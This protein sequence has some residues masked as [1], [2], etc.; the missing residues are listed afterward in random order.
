MNDPHV[1]SLLYRLDTDP[2]LVFQN[3]PPLDYETPDFR[4]RLEDGLL[5]VTMKGHYAS[6]EEAQ[7]VVQPFL[8]AWELDFAL[9]RGK[10]EM[11][12]RFEKAN[13]KDRN[14]PPPGSSQVLQP[15]AAECVLTTSAPMVVIGQR[16]YPPPPSTPLEVTADV[17]TL[18][19]RYERAMRDREPLPGAGYFCLTI[20]EN[21]FGGI[22]PAPSGPRQPSSKRRITATALDVHVDVLS[23]LGELTTER[24]DPTSTARKANIAGPLTPAEEEWVRAAL[25]QLIRRAAMIAAGSLPSHQLTM[26]DLPKLL[27]MLNDDF[28]TALDLC[29]EQAEVHRAKQAI[30]KDER[31]QLEREK[32]RLEKAIDRLMDQIEIGQSVKDRLKLR[33]EE[34]AQVK[35]RIAQADVPTLSRDLLADSLKPLGPLCALGVGDPVAIRQILRKIRR[36]SDHRDT[37]RERME[38]RGTGALQGGCTPKD[39]R[40]APQ[41]PRARKRP[42]VAVT[43]LELALRFEGLEGPPTPRLQAAGR[44]AIR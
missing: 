10:R 38:V 12:F 6:A 44:Y 13:L 26:A 16:S 40:G 4:L 15:F 43:L 3:P 5:T 18:W 11:R 1:E 24:G 27:C 9:A 22:A 36:D 23:K 42:G 21:L 29:M 31:V 33:E 19:A 25:R 28:D 20:L 7:R 32:V 30:P 35:D 17:A 34:L 37:R 14:P 2:T 39:S 8:D 41:A